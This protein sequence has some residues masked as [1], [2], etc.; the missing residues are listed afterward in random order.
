[1]NIFLW[2]LAV[3]GA[4]I[5]VFLISGLILLISFRR[6]NP[7]SDKKAGERARIAKRVK[8]I[9]HPSTE[10]TKESSNGE[11]LEWLKEQFGLGTKK[12]WTVLLILSGAVLLFYRGF[13]TEIGVADVGNLSQKYWLQIFIVYGVGAGLIWLNADEKSAKVLQKVLAGGVIA[14]LV[15]IPWYSWVSSPSSTP[16]QNSLSKIPMKSDPKEFRMSLAKNGTSERIPVDP[17]KTVAMFGEEFRLHCVYR[18]GHE[19]SFRKGETPCPKGDMPWVYVT[20]EA[21][22]TNIILY[23]YVPI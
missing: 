23:T 20:N 8:D 7:H 19:V 21:R 15:V 13:T 5:I 9:N 22:E 6:K 16:H 2:I 10:E 18:D 12:F 3:I 1:M 4:G 14:L 11:K 17:G